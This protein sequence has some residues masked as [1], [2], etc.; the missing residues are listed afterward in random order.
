MPIAG[1]SMAMGE[2]FCLWGFPYRPTSNRFSGA[3]LARSGVL[4]RG[5][6]RGDS[7]PEKFFKK[8]L[9]WPLFL[10]Q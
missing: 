3:S 2:R 6:N 5:R 10:A 1:V 7:R 4:W 9:G 8:K